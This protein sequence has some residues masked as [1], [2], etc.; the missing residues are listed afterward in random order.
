MFG[1]WI[2][3]LARELFIKRFSAVRHLGT[4]LEVTGC[5]DPKDLVKF[6][7]HS[8]HLEKRIKE[9]DEYAWAM[10]GGVPAMSYIEHLISND[11]A[12][13]QFKK[14]YFPNSPDFKPAY[15]FKGVVDEFTTYKQFYSDV[16]KLYAE[17]DV[18]ARKDIADRLGKQIAALEANSVLLNNMN[19]RELS[20]CF[21]DRNPLSA[22]ELD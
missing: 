13:R 11:K 16:K 8:V 18:L 12:L 17:V 21:K 7:K 2:G 4:L 9:Q 22:I 1:S 5:N 15:Y 10:D 3:L 20:A 19:M 14:R 6:A